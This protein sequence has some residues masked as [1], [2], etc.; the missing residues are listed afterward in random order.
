MVAD[1]I[2]DEKPIVMAS[3]V[4]GDRS[5][6]K[7]KC[8]A[9][10]IIRIIVLRI[11]NHLTEVDRPRCYGNW[12]GILSIKN[13]FLKEIFLALHTVSVPAGTTSPPF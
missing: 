6:V 2:R 3:P 10:Q 13:V 11:G 9:G 5:L 1:Q 7:N 4:R 12:K 8:A